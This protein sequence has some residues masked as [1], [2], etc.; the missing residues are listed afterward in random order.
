MAALSISVSDSVAVKERIDESVQ[1]ISLSAPLGPML[2]GMRVLRKRTVI[3]SPLQL[4]IFFDTIW[5]NKLY[6][7]Y[8]GCIF[9]GR[10]ENFSDRT[11]SIKLPGGFDSF[12]TGIRP[13][14]LTL[15]AVDDVDKNVDFGDTLS[16]RPHPIVKLT[17]EAAD[18]DGDAKEDWIYAGKVPGCG[19]DYTAPIIGRVDRRI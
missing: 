3:V 15:V 12:T 11:I 4:I 18:A 9:V 16:P 14:H 1:P 17:Y 6:Q 2:A 5:T 10:T 8:A 13:Y 7:A 19:P